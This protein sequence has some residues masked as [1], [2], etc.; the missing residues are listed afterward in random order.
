MSVSYLSIVI[1][2]EYL[3]ASSNRS[4][5]EVGRS[6]TRSLRYA[7]PVLPK[8][9]GIPQGNGWRNAAG[10]SFRFGILAVSSGS[11]CLAWDSCAAPG[12]PPSARSKAPSLF[13]IWANVAAAP[14]VPLT[15]DL[16][17][18]PGWSLLKSANSLG[19][20]HPG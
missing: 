11:S 13:S 3:G 5:H 20:Y 10:T 19:P 8:S 4:F 18:S 17:C 14:V 12:T 9:V 2:P 1:L 16:T 6:D 7:Y 15:S